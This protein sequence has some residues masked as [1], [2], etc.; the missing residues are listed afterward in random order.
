[1]KML[2]FD[3]KPSEEEY[4]KLNC[5]DGYEIEFRENSLD[6]KYDLSEDDIKNASVLSVART[7]NLSKKVLSK[8]KNLMLISTRSTSCNHIDLDYCTNH[9]IAVVNIEDYGIKSA[10]QF[11]IGMII[12]LTRNVVP[13]VRDLRNNKIDYI[14]YE[15]S[16]L[17]GLRLGIIGGDSV[18][19]LISEYAKNLG[20]KV[21]MS[22]YK[23]DAEIEKRVCYTPFEELLEKADIITIHLPQIS[24]YYHLFNREM[25]SK[26]KQDAYIIN[27]SNGEIIDLEALY[28]FI[29]DKKIKGAALDIY[30]CEN[31]LLRFN[32]L[33]Y[34]VE[35]I[36]VK[37]VNNV[38]N[39][40]R[41]LKLKNV[42][43]TP[44]IAFYTKEASNILLKESFNSIRDYFKGMNTNRVC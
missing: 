30:E 21:M 37:C 5:F 39:L 19:K 26:L 10:A 43:I 18:A 6:E 36:N 3:Y 22:S 24:E 34:L 1:M 44:R 29:N 31:M 16:V 35:N 40:Q 4:F 2:F 17:N 20:M 15:G 11:V 8:F 12:N 27:I 28:Q 32:D 14:K 38:E 23:Y 13:A 25:L 42:I 9:K 33:Q 41:L 7:S